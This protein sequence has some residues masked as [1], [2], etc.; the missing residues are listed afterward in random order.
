MRLA[1]ADRQCKRSSVQQRLCKS[2]VANKVVDV[3]RRD[4]AR[5]ETTLVR[6]GRKQA[7]GNVAQLARLGDG[8]E[9]V[10]TAIGWIYETM[11]TW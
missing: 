9:A 4:D 5:V 8:K 2:G 6:Q 11:T 10:M 7:C 3:R 1:R